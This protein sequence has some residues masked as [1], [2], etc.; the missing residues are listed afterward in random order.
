MENYNFYDLKKMY[1]CIT[2]I[3]Y[4]G[5]WVT[6]NSPPLRLL[7][8]WHKITHYFFPGKYGK[9]KVHYSSCFLSKINFVPNN[10]PTEQMRAWKEIIIIWVILQIPDSIFYCNPNVPNFHYW[11]QIFV[12]DIRSHGGL[13]CNRGY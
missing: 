12:W 11:L 1:Q 10:K 13:H 2:E 4:I 8:K 6:N 9:E 7:Y 3:E 5:V